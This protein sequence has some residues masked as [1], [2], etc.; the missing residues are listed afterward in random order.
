MSVP[1][2]HGIIV[3]LLSPPTID[4]SGLRSGVPGPIE[5]TRGVRALAGEV[6]CQAAARL[7]GRLLRHA[8]ARDRDDCDEMSDPHYCGNSPPIDQ[9]F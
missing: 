4:R 6:E 9:F 1:Y 3:K 8:L 2:G 7:A 5:R